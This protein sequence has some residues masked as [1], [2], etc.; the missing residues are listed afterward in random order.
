MAD[1][2]PEVFIVFLNMFYGYLDKLVFNVSQLSFQ[3]I[4]IHGYDAIAKTK[5]GLVLVQKLILLGTL[6]GNLPGC[7]VDSRAISDAF[8]D[9]LLLEDNKI[10]V[11]NA[12]FE[13]FFAMAIVNATIIA[14]DEFP[15]EVF[16]ADR[17]NWFAQD[18]LKFTIAQREV[19]MESWLLLKDVHF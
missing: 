16:K 5:N 11:A 4:G 14:F 10:K 2:C 18:I 3:D 12:F 7:Y 19:E 9:P 1:A 6:E 15:V 17:D 8:D 13:N